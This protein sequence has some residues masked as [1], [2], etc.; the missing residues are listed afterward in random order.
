[1]PR[2]ENLGPNLEI[3]PGPQLFPLDFEHRPLAT[4]PWVVSL[5]SKHTDYYL[6][7]TIYAFRSMFYLIVQWFELGG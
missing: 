3:H 7:F 2:T 1:V 4:P 5:A 6:L